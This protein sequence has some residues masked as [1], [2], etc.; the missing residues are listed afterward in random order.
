MLLRAAL[1]VGAMLACVPAPRVRAV[2][3]PPRAE[4]AAASAG[5]W[6]LRVSVKECAL[7]AAAAALAGAVLPLPLAV[8]LTVG[9]ALGAVFTCF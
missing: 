6:Q 1:V 9:L 7:R 4:S 2:A 5:G 8:P 3:S